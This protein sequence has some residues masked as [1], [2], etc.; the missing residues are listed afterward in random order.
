MHHRED[1]VAIG[2]NSRLTGSLM[3]LTTIGLLGGGTASGAEHEEGDSSWRTLAFGSRWEL[4][5]VP[6]NE[7]Y[8]VYI[9][10]PQRTTFALQRMYFSESDIIDTGTPRFGL[11]LGGR[12]GLLRI[13]PEG[14]PDRGFQVNL[15]VGFNGQ[16]DHENSQDNVGWDGIY[17]L[18]FYYKPWER[19]A[20]RFGA[21]HT[22]SHRGD[23]Y[24]E[25]T[26]RLRI[27]YTREELLIGVSRRI[28]E[29]WHLYGE[30]GS[31]HDIGERPLQDRGRLQA[32]LQYE[33]EPII[34][35]NRLGWYAAIDLSA[36]EERDWETNVA[37]QSGLV[38]KT[39]GH[40]WRVGVEY[41]NGRSWIGEF[42]QDDESYVSF[43]IWLDL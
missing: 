36:Y 3:L 2:L 14:N 38:L 24:I 19:T 26:G 35:K 23:E 28:G 37:L 9:A 13:H 17:S 29:R 32:G 41:Y 33:T 5:L 8:P 18:I 27:G 39:H 30:A 31:A 22:S 10:D 1:P 6:G 12:L 15:E 40:A 4:T 7:L 11:K 21:H 20:F 42:F 25:R 43:G 34:W 16:F